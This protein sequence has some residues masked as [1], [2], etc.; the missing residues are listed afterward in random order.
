MSPVYKEASFPADYREA[1]VRQIMNTLYR[2][3]SIAITGLAGMGKSNVVRFLVSHPQVQ[4]RYLGERAG[5]YAFLHVDCAGLAHNSED[6]ILGEIAAQLHYQGLATST[7]DLPDPLRTLRRSLKAQIL[8]L[9]PKLDLVLVMDYFD[10]AAVALDSA[11]FNYLFHLRNARPQ[12][13]LA[14]IFVTRRPMGHLHELNELLDESCF[15]GPLNRKDALDSLRR[16]EARLNITFSPAQREQLIA[17][18]GG[19]PASSKTAASFFTVGPSTPAS[20]QQ[21]SPSSCC[22]LIR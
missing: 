6:E 4:S 16:D 11:F 20:P 1:E 19:H 3:R 5:N 2:R 7:V 10:E 9:A 22:K 14:Y 17:C 12:G 18:T 15:V 21:R 8:A 13:N